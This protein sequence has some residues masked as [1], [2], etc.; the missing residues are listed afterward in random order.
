MQDSR[1]RIIRLLPHS[2]VKF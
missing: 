1:T 2:V